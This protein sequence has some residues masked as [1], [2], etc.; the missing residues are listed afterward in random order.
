MKK[1]DLLEAVVKR[2]KLDTNMKQLKSDLVK[3][4]SRLP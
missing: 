4:L 3:L 2:R 1:M